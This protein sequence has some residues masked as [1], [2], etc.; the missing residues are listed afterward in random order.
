MT[1]TNLPSDAQHKALQD[2]I[3]KDIAFRHRD[4][5]K[6]KSILEAGARFSAP[7]FSSLKILSHHKQ[8]RNPNTTNE[9]PKIV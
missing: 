7:A 2:E 9:S 1:D 5:I 8:T 4:L 3:D 6:I